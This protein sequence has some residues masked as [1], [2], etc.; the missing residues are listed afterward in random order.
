VRRAGMRGRPHRLHP[1]APLSSS[2]VAK[3]AITP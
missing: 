3:A 1:V 2:A